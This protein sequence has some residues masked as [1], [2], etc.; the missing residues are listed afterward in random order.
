MLELGLL[1]PVRAV[2]AGRELRLGGPRQRAVLAL[3]VVEAGR[4]VPAGRLI[5][6]LWRGDPPPGAATTL[7]S[8]VS[9]LRGLLAPDATLVALGGGYLLTLGSGRVD[10]V[11]FERLAGAGRALADVADVEALALEAARL[12]ELRLVALEGRI[13]AEL[14]LGRHAE[15]AAELERL[16]GEHPV[17]ERLWYLLV[18][19][20]YRGGRQADALAAYQR[21]R[22]VL[23]GEL[24]L[25]P[26]ME[27]R[28]LE[29]QVLRHEVPAVPSPTR[30]G[31]LPVP[32]TGLV[33]RERDLAEVGRLLSGTRLVTL[34]GPGGSGKTRLALEAA[35]RAAD[36]FQ[37]GAWLAGLAG[38][39]S[40]DLVGPRVM[41]ALGVRQDGDLPVIDALRW[42]LRPAE[43]LL[44][45]D[46]CEH[47]LD[48]CAELAG[49][50]LADCPGL[51]VLATSRE[52]L[53]VPGE[54]SYPVPPLE[55]P[56]ETAGAQAIS[57][58]PAVRLFLDRASAAKAGAAAMAAPVEVIARICRALD[59]LPLAIELAAAR[60]STLSAGEIEAHLADK[61]G[62]LRHRRPVADPRHQTLK[63][64]IDWSYE[65][66][67]E[68][69]R[70]VFAELSVFAGGFGLQSAAAVCCGGNEASALELIDQLAAK[71]LVTAQ[72]APGATRYRMLETVR[73]YAASR[74]ADAGEDH[75]ARRRHAAAFLDIAER[76]R[77]LAVLAR[78]QDNFRAALGYS[79]S[80]GDET[81][82]RLAA[83]LGDFWLA[84]GFFQEGRGWL[85]RALAQ[86][87]A[88][89]R[90]R[91]ELLRLLGV[92]LYESGELDR[93]E[94]VLSEGL[95]IAGSP[96]AQ[97]RIRCV[98]AE[99]SVL[100]GGSTQKALEVC[101]AAAP[102]LESEGDLDGAAQAWLSA[103]WM[104]YF[105]GD[106]P[107]E[108]QCL[109]RAIAHARRSGN[110]QLELRS[111]MWL[112]ITFITLR[113]PADVAI[114]RVEQ[115]V[116]DASGEPWAQAEMLQQLALLYA[117]AGRIADAR[118]A[119][120]RSRPTLIGFGAGLTLAIVPFHSGMIELIAGDPAAAER[121]LR[122]GYEV[123]QA[124]GEQGYLAST[125][126]MLAEA[127]YAQDD[128]DEAEQLT[129][130]A[131]ALVKLEDKANQARWRATRAKL[132]ARRGQFSAAARLAD[133]AMELV[134]PTS[135]AA[136]QAELLTAKAEVYRLAGAPDQSEA[137]LRRALEIYQGRGAVALAERTT[138][139]LASLAA[140]SSTG[141]A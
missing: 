93:A 34:T 92:V 17:R 35:A 90:L 42:R 101:Q 115:L 31:N 124:M 39:A 114:S 122:A 107:A 50:L 25:D 3:L 75:R 85:E 119:K 63:A 69:E 104:H 53:G 71:S 133:Q 40:A 30:Q 110:R 11:E 23:A 28:E 109:E 1:G 13:E 24:G 117:Y 96:A 51:R 100:H 29:Q 70:R 120:A 73:E 48:A 79:L 95:R 12:E 19:A 137:S 9:R 140:R 67:S 37:D 113:V 78:E 129:A 26:G 118:A 135:W 83:T 27:L 139:A 89:G 62:F 126:A 54:V 116:Q 38:I 112:A 111:R 131:E 55:L 32:L 99:I 59:G 45:L 141:S 18:L 68:D 87:V 97:A 74:L 128:L 103:G 2:R 123:L 47:L 134:A 57:R 82:A 65:L 52:P 98:L 21:A 20:L 61:F 10:A 7:R 127:V 121:E 84:R 22:A 86:D 105:I 102:M 72:T 64:A 94:S 15:V 49:V 8:Y 81:G 33:G 4:V 46:N 77:D 43:L 125:A 88:Q 56:P 91:A 130:Q 76:E 80:T 106:S 138:A 66:L 44:V 58:A 108:E 36:R 14:T 16:V 5:E 41:E 132:L 136:L 60:A 6:E